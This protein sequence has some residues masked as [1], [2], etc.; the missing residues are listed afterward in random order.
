MHPRASRSL[1]ALALLAVPLAGCAPRQPATIA[2][3]PTTAPA[4]PTATARPK[5]TATPT[6]RPK[7]TSTA[8]PEPQ[9]S[10][11]PERPAGSFTQPEATPPAN[12]PGDWVFHDQSA[13]GFTFALPAG[14][15]VQPLTLA[16]SDQQFEQMQE[17]VPEMKG[18]LRGNQARTLLVACDCAAAARGVPSFLNV[19][20][21]QLP[22]E[23]P[24]D[25]VVENAVAMLKS[26]SFTVEPINHTR[27]EHPAGPAEALQ[28]RMQVD[29]GSGVSQELTATQYVLMSSGRVLVVT[30]VTTVDQAEASLRTFYKIGQTFRLTAPTTAE[31][32]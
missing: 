27:I 12:L 28:Y 31:Q 1:A 3:A 8:T 5:P 2:A 32:M 29:A 23:V 30:I 10:A 19:N 15:E 16:E 14:W 25:L 24:F 4:T 26:L 21:E 22:Y 6:P 20:I 18:V 11:A 9:Q 13:L 7:P 17:D